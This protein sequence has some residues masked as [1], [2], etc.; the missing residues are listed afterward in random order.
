[1][2]QIVLL[3]ITCLALLVSM[4]VTAQTPVHFKSKDSDTIRTVYIWHADRLREEAKDSA[5]KIQSLIGN[6]K[7][8]EE[9]T[10]MYC[11]S[12]VLNQKDNI[13]EAFGKVHI[14]DSDTTNIFSDYMK[15]LVDKKLVFFHKNVKLTDGKG[16]LYTEDLQ[17]DMNGKI[18]I[19]TNGGRVVNQSTVL[20]SKEGTYYAETKDIYFRKNVVMKDPRYDLRAD[21][22]LYNTQSKLATFITQTYIRDSS[23]STIVTREGNYDLA[24]HRAEFGKRPVINQGT[25]RITGDIVKIDEVTGK[26][27][28]TGNAIYVDS[29]QGVSVISN[30]MIVDKKTNTFLATGSPLMILKQDKDSIYISADTLFS[31]IYSDSVLT[32]SAAQK[33]TLKG[34]GRITTTSSND[35]SKRYLQGYHHVRIFSDSLQAVSDSLFYSV[36]DSVFQLFTD[37]IVWLNGMPAFAAQT[38]PVMGRRHAEHILP[39]SV[40]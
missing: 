16:T 23:G 17:Y 27:I 12:M 36:R 15:Y 8:Q 39:R 18:G 6:V 19:Y 40:E 37:P 20:T 25:Q 9:N 14:N 7:L 21:S 2:K 38:Q 10:F 32:D 34:V 3:F 33:D 24:N 35:S 26:S 28:A 29:A 1:M 5:N 4:R 30:R 22:L 31:G 13:V 11:D